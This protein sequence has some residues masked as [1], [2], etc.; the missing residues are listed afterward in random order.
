M[1]KLK[2]QY[3]G[4]LIRRADSLEKTLILGKIEGRGRRGWQRMRWLDGITNMMDKSWSKLWE[5]V[6]DREAWCAAAMRSQRVGHDWVTELNYNIKND[7]LARWDYGLY[8]AFLSFNIS[9]SLL[10]LMSIELVMPSNHLTLCHPLLPLPS[11]FP[12]I[13]VFSSEL[14]LRIRWPKFWSFSFSISPSS[15]YS[16]LISFRI[17]RCDLLAVQA[18]LK[19]LLL[20][21]SLKAS[22]LWCSAFFMVQLT[23]NSTFH[24][25]LLWKLIRQWI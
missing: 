12:R 15:E 11:I 9:Q 4:H 1:L 20:H 25:E 21:H 19:S 16:V 3:V 10:K 22:I 13:R 14:T 23:D 24:L 17:D 5:L 2:L 6:M 18:V 7:L 8:Q